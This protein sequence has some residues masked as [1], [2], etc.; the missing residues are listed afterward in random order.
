MSQRTIVP[1]LSGGFAYRPFGRRA[2]LGLNASPNADKWRFARAMSELKEPTSHESPESLHWLGESYLLAGDIEGAVVAF[3]EGLRD[4]TGAH[5]V[6]RAIEQTKDAKALSDLAAGYLLRADGQESLDSLAALN[7]SERAWQLA[8]GPE[9]AWNRALSMSAASSRDAAVAA[10]HDYLKREPMTE[11]SAEARQ[12]MSVAAGGGP[13]SRGSVRR[14]LF[15]AVS[16][17]GDEAVLRAAS[18]GPGF[19]RAIAEEELLP[20]WGAGDNGARTRAKR[21]GA[22]VARISGDF[23]VADSVAR[24]DA[25]RERAQAEEAYAAL[26][27]FGSGRKALAAYRYEEALPLLQAAEKRLSALNVPLAAQA[28]VLVATLHFYAKQPEQALA[29]CAEAMQWGDSTRYPSVTAQCAWNQGTIETGRRRYDRAK[30]AYE[31]ARTVFE[32]MRDINSM[33]AI[34]VRLEENDRWTGDVKNAW[35]HMVRAFR[36]GAEERGY[37]PFSEAAKVAD[38]AGMPFAAL[39]F[40]ELAIEAAR[41]SRSAVEQ[42]DGH[43][44]RA[45]LLWRLGRSVEA[46]IDLNAATRFMRAIGDR[47]VAARLESSLVL[48]RSTLV[49]ATRPEEVCQQLD[50]AIAELSGSGNRRKIAQARLLQAQAYLVRHDNGA[51]E[52]SLAAALA[53]VESQRGEISTDEERLALVDTA[54][55]ATETLVELLYDLNRTDE[56]LAAAE[57]SKARL[58]LD[59]MARNDPRPSAEVMPQ[60]KHGDAFVEYFVLPRRVLVWSITASGTRAHA[61]NIDRATLERRIDLRQAAFMSDDASRMRTLGGELFDVLLHPVWRDIESSR[62]LVF[63]ADGALYRVPFASLPAPGAFLVDGHEVANVPSLAWLAMQRSTVP[64]P[65]TLARVLAAVPSTGR[66]EAEASYVRLI[67]A[68]QDVR[69]IAARFPQA[70]VL[71]G[72]DVTAARIAAAAGDADLFH[73]AGHAVADN[74]RPGRSALVMSGGQLLRASEIAQW[75]LPRTPLVMLAACSTGAGRVTSDGTASLARAFLL[76]GARSAVA[77]LWPV[78]DETASEIS[79]HFYTALAAGSSASEAL[80]S[81]QRAL[82]HSQHTRLRHDWA[83]FQFIGS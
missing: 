80:R 19:A 65:F 37:I 76:A 78:S 83:A 4:E 82:I 44:S 49:M 33:A 75:R 9:V 1:R 43:L 2:N 81:A 48:A 69:A 36:N 22:A 74:R 6:S 47:T 23:I 61:V 14:A 51:A 64:A 41:V 29:I 42:T 58:L 18:E 56:A 46:R 57:R 27:S 70:V 7:A 40:Y 15:G 63:I 60:P 77:T 79:R 12:R 8:P 24:I 13:R 31:A 11:W 20:E 72:E 67:A 35:S 66:G 45:Q 34:E 21:I 68:E 10:W 55:E 17:S 30:A 39:A 59:A 73:F 38:A 53:E 32:R 52:R 71:T 16:H 62:R 50:Q 28:K 25:L 5:D 3:E 26:V 54:R